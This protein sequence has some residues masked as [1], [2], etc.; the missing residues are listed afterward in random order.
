MVKLD[1]TDSN[2]FETYLRYFC[3]KTKS[4]DELQLFRLVDRLATSINLVDGL[5]VHLVPVSLQPVFGGEPLPAVRAPV[6][7]GVV[8]QVDGHHVLLEV[9]A[10]PEGRAAHAA[11]LVLP[12]GV[13]GAAV[14]PQAVGLGEPSPALRAEEQ[15]G[16]D[17]GLG[18]LE[19]VVLHA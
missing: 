1:T 2:V 8:G 13:D 16:L 10:Q 5:S 19:R 18:V 17:L 3:Y 12:A 15:L 9:V 14:A 7:L 4:L 11:H 6:P